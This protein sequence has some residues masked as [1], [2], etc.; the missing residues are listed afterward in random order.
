MNLELIEKDLAALDP[1]TKRWSA[2]RIHTEYLRVQN[3][4]IKHLFWHP[5]MSEEELHRNLPPIMEA[6]IFVM[7][8]LYR[9]LKNLNLDASS[10]KGMLYAHTTEFASVQAMRMS[11]SAGVAHLRNAHEAFLREF[12]TE[13][14]AADTLEFS[15][16]LA[17]KVFHCAC[18]NGSLKEAQRAFGRLE[19][20]GFEPESRGQL[21]ATMMVN[22]CRKH[23]DEQLA[24]DL[25][26]RY[27]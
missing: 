5:N 13:M 14:T 23:R 20:L 6:R 25:V 12:E 7:R 24:L 4:H 3:K 27:R 19:K 9:T 8:R 17:E 26:R 21:F 18:E 1:K 22:S 11:F 15:R 16:R 10:A 2:K